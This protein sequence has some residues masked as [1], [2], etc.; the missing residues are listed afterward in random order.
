MVLNNSKTAAYALLQAGT[1]TSSVE[2]AAVI[3]SEV[4]AAA[5]QI[6]DQ[7]DQQAID[8]VAHEWNA[9][10]MKHKLAKAA[11]KGARGRI[12]NWNAVVL[13]A[14]VWLR[15]TRRETRTVLPDGLLQKFGVIKRFLKHTKAKAWTY[16]TFDSAGICHHRWLLVPSVKL[17]VNV[18]A[19]PEPSSCADCCNRMVVSTTIHATGASIGR[20]ALAGFLI[21]ET[22]ATIM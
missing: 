11:A 5:L 7:E 2:Q 16:D 15:E 1:V 3:A 9:A 18:I 12:D 6:A 22:T 4:A 13:L 10:K 19:H 17:I 20:L 21:K 14:D 8:Q